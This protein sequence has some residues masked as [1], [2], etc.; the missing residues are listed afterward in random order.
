VVLGGLILQ[1][2]GEAHSLEHVS[3]CPAGMAEPG[4]LVMTDLPAIAIRGSLLISVSAVRSWRSLSVSRLLYLR[5]PVLN[6]C[7]RWVGAK[8]VQPW[9]RQS[10]GEIVGLVSRAH[11]SCRYFNRQ[12]YLCSD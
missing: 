2:V 12:N 6:G 10:G 3:D 7:Q 11:L 4:W 5:Q 1:A 9:S 8:M